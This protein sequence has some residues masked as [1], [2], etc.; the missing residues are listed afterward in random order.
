MGSVGLALAVTAA[1]AGAAVIPPGT[2]LAAKQE[3]V[4]NNGSEPETLDPALIES[5]IGRAHV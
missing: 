1:A 2:V 5:E 4:R 3:M